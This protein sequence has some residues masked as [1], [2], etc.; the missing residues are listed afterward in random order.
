[1]LPNVREVACGKWKGI[2]ANF[3][4]D[5]KQLSGR[6]T[7][8]PVCGGN[9]RFRLDDKD[10][11]GTFYCNNCGAGDGVELVKLIRGCEFKQAALEIEKLAGFVRHEEHRPA[12][13]DEQKLEALKRVWSESK[14][15]GLGD[16]AAKYLAGRGLV[17]PQSLRFHPS[18]TYRD[19]DVITKYP[20]MIA[21]VQSPDGRGV[22]IHRTFLQDGKKAPVNKPK[23][24][25]PGLPI[26][27]AAI[28]LFAHEETI[29]VAEGIETAI[30]ATMLHNIPTWSCISAIGL[31]GFVW[32]QGV[33]RL[34]VFSDNDA[35][36]T[37][38]S[39]AFSLAK[40]CSMAGI[41]CDVRV[42]EKTGT[43]WADAL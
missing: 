30:A 27:G 19:G 1:M 23:M 7:K 4:L 13:S 10:G 32:P 26:S 12:K 34:V 20:A 35:N 29:G 14:A 8:C 33:T 6:H 11:R 17:I 41:Q 42:P 9:D 3:G 37:G 36:Y 15:I 31:A 40:R 5:E 18:M 22:S 28:R 38:Q 16:M 39:A 43:D 24:L 2:L 25:M 21:K